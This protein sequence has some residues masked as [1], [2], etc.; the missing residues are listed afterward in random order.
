MIIGRKN[1]LTTANASNIL[2]IVV[3]LYDTVYASNILTI[4]VGLYDTVVKVAHS[5]G[6]KRRTTSGVVAAA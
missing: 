3:G 6:Q 1:R 5:W 2:T 4:V